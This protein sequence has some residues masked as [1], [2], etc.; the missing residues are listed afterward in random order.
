LID[1]GRVIAQTKRLRRRRKVVFV[2]DPGELYTRALR[3]MR[4]VAD[5]LRDLPDPDGALTRLIERIEGERAWVAAELRLGLPP[6]QP[7]RWLVPVGK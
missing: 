6:Q 5:S 7:P 2:D 1:A 4:E 3:T